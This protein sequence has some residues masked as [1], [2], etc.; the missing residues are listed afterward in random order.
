MDKAE[1]EGTPPE[2]IPEIQSRMEVRK[3]VK[4]VTRK[5]GGKDI[6]WSKVKE[7]VELLKKKCAD[8]SKKVEVDDPTDSITVLTQ[9]AK[10]IR[11]MWQDIRAQMNG[12]GY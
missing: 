4:V 3:K 2:L 8:F 10:E 9:R 5:K 7:N 11:M 1:S 12:K 6:D